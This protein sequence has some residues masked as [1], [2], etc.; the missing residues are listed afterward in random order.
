[1]N[2][3]L[4]AMR[5][6]GLATCLALALGAGPLPAAADAGLP[7]AFDPGRIRNDIE[8][9]ASDDFEGRGP[10][11][12]GEARTVSF[13][14]SEFKKYGLKAGNPDGTYV[15]A[16]PMSG[17]RAT[18]TLAL[19]HGSDETRLNFP[20][21]FVAISYNREPVTTIADSELVFVGYGVVAP[22]YGWD[23]YKGWTSRARLL[24]C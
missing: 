13:L 20:D 6:V 7:A 3:A 11:T 2:H 19:R 9:L 15:Q 8:I 10:G 1:M 12:N 18:P 5:R 24:S 22:E 16:V 17:F 14:T 4:P 21:Q 23:D